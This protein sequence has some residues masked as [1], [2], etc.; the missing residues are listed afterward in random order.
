VADRTAADIFGHVFELLAE[1]PT[2]ANKALARRLWPKRR[3][4]DFH[5]R[6]MGADDA[7]IALGL[8]RSELRTEDGAEFMGT[9]YVLDEDD[10]G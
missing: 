7:L 9:V 8:A 5:P 10:N 6:Q 3:A 2:E 1:D 4:Y